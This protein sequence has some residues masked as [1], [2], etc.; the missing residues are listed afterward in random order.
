[1]EPKNIQKAYVTRHQKS[2]TRILMPGYI[3]VLNIF[4]STENFNKGKSFENFLREC[5]VYNFINFLKSFL[6][7]Y[8]Y[9]F[10]LIRKFS[11]RNIF[12]V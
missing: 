3:L 7:Y 2:G 5:R 10:W 9:I 11:I 1:M 12:T 4:C 6:L 8:H